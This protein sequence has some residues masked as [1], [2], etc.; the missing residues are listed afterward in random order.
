MERVDW[1]D[2]PV[3]GLFRLRSVAGAAISYGEVDRAEPAG[4]AVQRAGEGPH[5]V[6]H[7]LHRGHGVRLFHVRKTAAAVS[8]CRAGAHRKR[9]A[10]PAGTATL[11]PGF[12]AAEERRAGFFRC[13]RSGCEARSAD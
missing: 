2:V 12:R 8:A 5:A 13:P 11:R 10:V 7:A 6:L 9:S 3:A 4:L 1:L